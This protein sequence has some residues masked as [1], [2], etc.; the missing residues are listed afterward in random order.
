MEEAVTGREGTG[1]RGGGVWE[2]GAHDVGG[3]SRGRGNS[4]RGDGWPL[5]GVR[6]QREVGSNRP[7]RPEH[8]DSAEATLATNTAA[9]DVDAGEAEQKG[10]HGLRSGGR[11][12]LGPVQEALYG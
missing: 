8:L 10:G 12:R 9:L 5:G 4:S 2:C 7:N 1:R 6:G 3:A 11:R